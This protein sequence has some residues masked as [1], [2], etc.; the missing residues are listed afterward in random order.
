MKLVQLI[1]VALFASAG[2]AMAG[3]NQDTTTSSS[4]TTSK[5]ET[6]KAAS[7]DFDALD[8]NG[9]GYLSKTEA[10]DKVSDYTV[11]DRNAD[12]RLD[13][14]EFSAMELKG[15]SSTDTTHSTMH[16][17]TDTMHTPSDAS[18]N[19]TETMQPTP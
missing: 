16:Q 12:G 17:S 4:T 3:E 15:H 8:K 7:G 10:Q 13:R 6:W 1:G 18:P 2:V 11:A 9:D 19:P 14:A 5:S